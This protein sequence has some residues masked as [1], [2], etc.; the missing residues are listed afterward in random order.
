[1][2]EKPMTEDEIEAARALD[3][4]RTP[5]EW[6]WFGNMKMHEVDLATV[7]RGRVFV[8]Q[9]DRWGMRGAQ[10]RFQVRLNGE[11]GSGIMRDLGDLGPALGPQMIGSHRNDFIG[12]GHPDARFIAAC[13]TLVP[14]LL[15][16]V[17]RLRPAL[18]VCTDLLAQLKQSN[19]TSDGY[20]DAHMAY[21]RWA[22][23]HAPDA[24]SDEAKRSVIDARLAE[25]DRLRAFEREV[26]DARDEIAALRADL[27]HVEP[28]EEPA[29]P[30]T[31]TL[32]HAC[33]CCGA[34]LRAGEDVAHFDGEE[35]EDVAIMHWGPCPEPGLW[36]VQHEGDQSPDDFI[37]RPFEAAYVLARNIRRWC[38]LPSIRLV[39]V[40]KE[41][42]RG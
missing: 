14:R 37:P 34:I 40:R 31:L 38:R 28:A 39:R 8:M 24:T 21:Q 6:Q 41:P 18:T 19:A 10:P 35:P 4:A 5:G 20:R 16:E 27:G 26:G 15:R 12:I 33:D 2:S 3:A 22:A 13:S 7:D 9:F 11:P 36:T 23:V 25:V 32:D 29:H 17:D 30:V 1:M 42:A